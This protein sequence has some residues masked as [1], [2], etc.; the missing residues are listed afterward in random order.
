LT[1]LQSYGIKK[2]KEKKENKTGR[3]TDQAKPFGIPITYIKPKS[4]K[5]T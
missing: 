3:V 2:K 1:L 4:K 5:T